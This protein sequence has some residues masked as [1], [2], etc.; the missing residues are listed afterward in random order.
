MPGQVL[1]TVSM[2]VG[3]GSWRGFQ[4]GAAAEAKFSGGIYGMLCLP[5]GCVLVADTG[6]N[7]IRLLSADLQEVSTVAGDGEEGHRD[8]AAAQA[9]FN[10]PAGLALLPYGRVLVGDGE[11]CNHCIRLLSADL[12]E[13]STLTIDGVDNLSSFLPLPDGRVLV[14]GDCRIRVL[15]G[16]VAAMGSKPA[17]KPPKKKKTKRALAGGASASSS[18]GAPG[19]ALKRVR[20]G[21]GPS[22]AAAAASSSSSSSSSASSED[23][24]EGGS[25]AAAA[26]DVVEPLV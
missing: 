23:E 26:L 19:P 11:Y 6:N 3:T 4:D 2:T 22:S 8:G 24:A 21:P 1:V 18:G 13:V 20:S 25:A 16:L 17:A 10:G 5:D 12:Q 7:R 15:E 9:R 14:A